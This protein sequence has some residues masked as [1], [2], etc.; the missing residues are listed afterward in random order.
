MRSESSDGSSSASPS[1]LI[2]FSRSPV[3]A[4]GSSLRLVSAESQAVVL[5]AL[6]RRV[7]PRST[8]L[9]P[10]HHRL[11]VGRGSRLPEEREALAQL[12]SRVLARLVMGEA[13]PQLDADVGD[14]ADFLH[15]FFRVGSRAVGELIVPPP[16]VELGEGYPELLGGTCDRRVGRQVERVDANRVQ[17]TRVAL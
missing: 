12:R 4:I 7:L 5:A 15:H 8:D 1:V 10:S 2:R 6:Q 3:R 9:V 11:V 17:M 16:P 14:A 13:D